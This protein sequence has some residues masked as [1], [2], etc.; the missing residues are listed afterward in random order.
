MQNNWKTWINNNN[1]NLSLLYVFVELFLVENKSM[2]SS[3]SRRT[4]QK[5][6]TKSLL[7]RQPTCQPTTNMEASVCCIVK[8]NHDDI[9]WFTYKFMQHPEQSS[10]RIAKH[11]SSW[12]TSPK[13]KF[14]KLWFQF[15][16]ATDRCPQEASSVLTVDVNLTRDLAEGVLSGA[17]VRPLV[18]RGKP[19]DCE[20]HVRVVVIAE[21]FHDLKVI[22][23]NEHFSWKIGQGGVQVGLVWRYW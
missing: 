7:R 20:G 23:R 22:V 11:N 13:F 8:Q 16:S 19:M 1:I 12:N 9:L 18:L 4:P 6:Q 17:L 3:T 21:G 14:C 5:C 15:Y 2:Y 10:Q